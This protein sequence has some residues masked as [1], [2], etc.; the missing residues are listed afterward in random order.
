MKVDEEIGYRQPADIKP[1]IVSI[2]A[3]EMTV[4]TLTEPISDLRRD[5]PMLPLQ[6]ILLV[7]GPRIVTTLTSS[8]LP[9]RTPS[10]C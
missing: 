10:L 6:V 5:E 9:K 4:E 2:D 3:E 7:K 1:R 8:D